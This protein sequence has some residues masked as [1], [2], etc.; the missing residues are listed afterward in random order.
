[1]RA[2]TDGNFF[3]KATRPGNYYNL[4]GRSLARS[5]LAFS[6]ELPAYLPILPNPAPSDSKDQFAA[7]RRRFR[8]ANGALRSVPRDGVISEAGWNWDPMQSDDI[9]MTRRTC[10]R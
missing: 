2:K 9:N 8:G 5:F 1:M 6:L 10:S 3:R 7:H 4:E